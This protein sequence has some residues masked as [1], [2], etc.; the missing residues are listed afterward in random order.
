MPDSLCNSLPWDSEFFGLRV[1]RLLPSRLSAGELA[2][3]ML[4]EPKIDLLFQAMAEATQ[5]AVLDAL[6]AADTTEGRAGHTRPGLRH[7]LQDAP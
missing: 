7:A 5:E 4:A 2:V 3:C 6:A 1:A